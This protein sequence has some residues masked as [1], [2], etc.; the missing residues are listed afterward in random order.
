MTNHRRQTV[1][2]YVITKEPAT[3]R[4]KD[5]AA[6]LYGCIA[7]MELKTVIITYKCT[8]MSIPN[9]GIGAIQSRDF[10]IEKKVRDPGIR[11]CNSLVA[12]PSATPCI[13]YPVSDRIQDSDYPVS[14]GIR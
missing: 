13:R 6:S 7:R 14:S 3:V 11:D 1:I 4:L 2:S 10:G 12:N 9:P 5:C 8:R